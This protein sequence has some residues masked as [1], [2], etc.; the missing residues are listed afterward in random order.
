MRSDLGLH[1]CVHERSEMLCSLHYRQCSSFGGASCEPAGKAMSK[2]CDGNRSIGPELGAPVEIP[3]GV[4]LGKL[5]F[6]AAW[7]PLAR[8]H[9]ERMSDL[10]SMAESAGI[11]YRRFGVGSRHE[12]PDAL[13]SS[14]RARTKNGE[15]PVIGSR[16]SPMSPEG[17]QALMLGPTTNG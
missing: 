1:I 3:Q 8:R 6:R 7:V 4:P 12:R 14:T 17:A 10:A 15:P 5:L 13:P 16:Q 11:R 9:L 2:E